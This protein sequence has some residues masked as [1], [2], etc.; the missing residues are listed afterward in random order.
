M[1]DSQTVPLNRQ[2]LVA[3]GLMLGLV[4]S[5]LDQTIV[6]TAMPTIA[7]QLGGLSLY[8]WVFAAYMLLETSAT[9]LFGKL[10]DLFGRR[11]VYLAG[12]LF[13][14]GGSILCGL[15]SSMI[16]LVVFRAMQG[17]G[18]A[19]LMPLSFTIIADVY[20]PAKRGRMQGIFG[21]ILTAASLAGP[22][23]GGLVTEKLGWHYAFFMNVPVGL[24][25]V[26][27]IWRGLAERVAEDKPSI[28]LAG[29][30]VFM[31]AMI[32]L[33]LTTV[34]GG[35]SF[36]W[37]S[38]EIIGLL[39]LFVRLERRAKDPMLPLSLFRDPSFA[40]TCLV[41]MLFG[42]GMFGSISYVPLYAQSVLGLSP[43]SS[44][45][46]MI[47]MMLGMGGA[48]IAAGFLMTKVSFRS[49]ALVGLGL[50]VSSFLLL[51]QMGASM[52]IAS[53]V[54]SM[55]LSGFGQ[56]ILGPTLV[57]AAQEFSQKRHRGVATSTNSFFRSIGGTFG[58]S[59]LGAVLNASIRARGEGAFAASLGRVFLVAAA[60]AAIGLIF[61]FFIR[62]ERLKVGDRRGFPVDPA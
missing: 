31:A 55:V 25:A 46:L 54:I 18:A 19:A 40:L 5:A 17:L 14:L 33:L 43:S 42:L 44:G 15:S 45:F 23:L 28:D 16:Q 36:A 47:F 51:S 34:W 39:V 6:T 41:V 2:S 37:I 59:I 1:Q 8:S 61:A 58:V 48:S 62:P 11:R 35:K 9:P 52:S 7:R 3:V 53:L 21:A 60:F 24:A 56:G 32:S 13:F 49:L 4:L 30:V 12:M 27:L 50:L 26:L 22:V 29:A 57:T 38:P 20:P 10:A